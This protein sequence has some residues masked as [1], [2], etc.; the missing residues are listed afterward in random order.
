MDETQHK[1]TAAY[2]AAMDGQT[3]P[4]DWPS[5][6][7][8]RAAALQ[9]QAGEALVAAEMAPLTVDLKQ[10]IAALEAKISDGQ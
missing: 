2:R 10:K 5:A 7:A 9:I 3:W 8:R 4:A 6:A 1:T